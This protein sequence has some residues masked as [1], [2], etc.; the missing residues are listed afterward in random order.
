VAK[1]RKRPKEDPGG[2]GDWIVTFSDCMTLLLCFFVLLLTFSSFE[3]VELQKF[4]GIFACE[5]NDSIFPAP[6]E[7]KDSVMP[8][9]PRT[10]DWTKK[11]SEMPAESENHPVEAD[12]SAAVI[13]DDSAHKDRKVFFMPSDWL[14]WGNGELLTREG[15][16]YL[17]KIGRFMEMVPS[18]VVI[19]E[20][21][22]VGAGGRSVRLD[23]SLAVM[24][25]FTT[26]Q[27]LS[28]DLFGITASPP[29]APERMRSRRV[30]AVTLIPGKVY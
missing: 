30:V 14:F 26:R 7:V 13:M 17:A 16:A 8:P 18:R 11:G 15:E 9:Y 21:G 23:R 29:E 28:G 1:E 2:P 24:R 27:K 10:V 25:F 5:S 6:R 4:A 22:P 3:E 20:V 19:G 12:R